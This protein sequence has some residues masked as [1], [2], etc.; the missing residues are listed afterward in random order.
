M[1]GGWVR[2]IYVLIKLAMKKNMASFIFLHP[3]DP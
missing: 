1:Q 2:K 3:V